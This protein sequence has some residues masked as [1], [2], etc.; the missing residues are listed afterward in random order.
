MILE[1]LNISA[2]GSINDWLGLPASLIA[3]CCLRLLYFL[4]GQLL[5]LQVT[6]I[7]KVIM[8]GNITSYS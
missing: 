8:G 3:V 1:H 5:D 4:P 2:A 7:V 6:G